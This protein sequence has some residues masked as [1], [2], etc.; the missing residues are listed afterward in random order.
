[1]DISHI[2]LPER[3]ARPPTSGK[4]EKAWDRADAVIE[5]MKFLYMA[6]TMKLVAHLEP[7]EMF[8]HMDYAKKHGENPK[9]F[10]RYLVKKDLDEKSKMQ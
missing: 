10:F 3:P 8:R 7:H 4:Q 6:E 2:K 5:I 1:M 9:S